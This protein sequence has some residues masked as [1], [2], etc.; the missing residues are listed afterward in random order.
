MEEGTQALTDAA[1]HFESGKS[2][3]NSLICLRQGIDFSL[4]PPIA[5][6]LSLG[7]VPKAEGQDFQGA[8]RCSIKA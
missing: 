7:S 2:F 3:I 5:L 4:R 8:E 6:S 1:E